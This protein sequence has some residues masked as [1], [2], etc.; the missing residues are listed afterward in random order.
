V[1]PFH[2]AKVAYRP[3]IAAEGQSIAD[4]TAIVIAAPMTARE[5]AAATA[6]Y[7]NPSVLIDLRAEGVTDPPPPIAPIITLADI[8]ADFQKAERLVD[9]RVAAAKEE[10]QLRAHSF[11]TRA[12]SNPSGWHD[13]CA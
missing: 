2:D 1:C 12:K 13:L 11:A 5:I 6:P 9:S 7:L 4:A 10:I 3:L 8:F